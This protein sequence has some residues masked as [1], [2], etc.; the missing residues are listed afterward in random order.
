M[1]AKPYIMQ[2]DL[3]SKPCLVV[4]AGPIAL[5]K[6]RHL[7][8]SGAQVTVVSTSF[9]AGFDD[10][11]LAARHTRAFEDSDVEGKMLVQAATQHLNVNARIAKLCETQG[12]M[13]CVANDTTLGNFGTPALLDVGDLRIAVSTNG[14]SPSYGARL[15]REIVKQLPEYLEEYLAFLGE[16][17]A[18][19]KQA[20]PDAP[21]RMRFNAYLA[22]PEFEILYITLDDEALDEMVHA[23]L[24][25]PETIPE[26]YTPKWG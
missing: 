14:L 20:I 24:E 18:M 22:S 2:I 10:L 13:C 26:S 16:K 5:H 15:R 9:H 12:I 8:D 19:S 23:L 3:D 6:T 4:G 25:H 17:R 11:D 21:L 1:S 7:L